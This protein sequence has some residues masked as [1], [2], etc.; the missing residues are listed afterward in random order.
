MFNRRIERLANAPGSVL[1]GG[2]MGER[3]DQGCG[4]RRHPCRSPPRTARG[5]TR[6]RPASR[7]FAAPSSMASPPPNSISSA[8]TRIGR[9]KASAAAGQCPHQPGA[10]R[11]HPAGRRRARLRHHPGLPPGLLRAG[12]ADHHRRPRSMPPSAPCGSG[13]A[14]LI[15]LSAKEAGRYHKCSPPPSPTAASSPSPPPRRRPRWRSPMTIS[16]RRG[17]SSR[18]SGSPISASA[19]SASPTMSGS[20][21]SAPISRPAGS[22]TRCAWR[23]ARWPFRATVRVWR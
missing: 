18:T 10:G 3:R 21:S 13:S 15:H 12:R 16:D 23:A 4:A 5:R 17:R 19:P 9:L 2:G 20:T 7:N 8:P 22:A 1:L 6:W 14:P 11:R